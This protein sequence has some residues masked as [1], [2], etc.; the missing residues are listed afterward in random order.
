ML[1]HGKAMSPYEREV[2]AALAMSASM[3]WRSV[4]DVGAR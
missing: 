1:P 2:T 4:K 3:C